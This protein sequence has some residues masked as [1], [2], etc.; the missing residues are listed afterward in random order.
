[1]QYASSD[2]RVL[3]G[4]A[5]VGDATGLHA[6]SDEPRGIAVLENGVAVAG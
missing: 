2:A 6:I 1:M 5:A 3:E 4:N